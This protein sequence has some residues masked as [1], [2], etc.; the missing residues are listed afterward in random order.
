MTTNDSVYAAN[1]LAA[2]LEGCAK[3]LDDLGQHSGV[4]KHLREAAAAHQSQ[5]ASLLTAQAERDTARSN[6]LEEAAKVAEGLDNAYDC[7][8]AYIADRIRSL[9]TKENPDG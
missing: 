2:R 4:A 6:A 1:M 7:R 3:A 9:K 5:A 8:G